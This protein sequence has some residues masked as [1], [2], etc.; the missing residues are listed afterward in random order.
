MELCKRCDGTGHDGNCDICG[1]S[2]FIELSSKENT[3]SS[4]YAPSYLWIRGSGNQFSEKTVP[5]RKNASRG[6]PQR[7]AQANKLASAKSEICG[8]PMSHLC[9]PDS[10][11]RSL[12]RVIAPQVSSLQAKYGLIKSITW[13]SPTE[14]VVVLSDGRIYREEF[15]IINGQFVSN[16]DVSRKPYRT[17][18]PKNKRQK[19][20]V[21]TQKKKKRSKKMLAKDKHGAFK[22]GIKEQ[23][24]RLLGSKRSKPV[25]RSAFELAFDRAESE[26]QFDGS[27]EWHSFRDS[28]TGQ[29]GSHPSFDPSD[30]Y[31]E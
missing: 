11:R 5:Q 29:F 7:P 8:I 28:G 23:A 16:P 6:Q 1:G 14:C 13:H 30:G 24:D 20:A 2:G 3:Y 12:K 17:V 31:E 15:E 21:E 10:M 27:R 18:V 26:R 19:P 9:F 25:E 4:T 22:Q